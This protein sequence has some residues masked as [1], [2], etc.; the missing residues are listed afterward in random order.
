MALYFKIEGDQIVFFGDTFNNRPVLKDLGARYNGTDKTWVIKDSESARTRA[1]MF[2]KP[3]GVT[4]SAAAPK[5][6]TSTSVPKTTAPSTKSAPL[7]IDPSMGLT[8]SQ[9]MTE[10]DKI[11]TQGFP[12]PIWV[13]GEIQSLSRRGGGTMYF[14]FADAKTGAHQTATMTVKCNI[15]QNQVTWLEK[16]HGKNKID[17]I[18]AD[19]NR[20]RAL[21]NVKLYKDRGQISLSIDDVDPTFTQGALALARLELLKKLRAQGLDRKNKLLT[22]PNFPFRVALITSEGSR[23]HTDFQHQ[24]LDS[25]QF[26]GELVFI[27]CSMQGDRVPAD[28]TKALKEAAAAHVDVIVISRGGGSAADLRWFDGEEIALAIANAPV[29]VIAAIG[30]HED[31]CVAEEICHT[32][33]KTPTAAA[34]RI[35]D[36]F[37]DTKAAID[38]KAHILATALDREMIRFDRM[39]ANLR[40]R[41]VQATDY[42]FSSHRDR[43]TRMTL[44]LQRGFDGVYSDQRAKFNRMGA[45]LS[46]FATQAIQKHVE[47]L[48]QR[49]QQLTKLNPKPWLDTGWTQLSVSGKNLKSTDDVKVGTKIQ[50]RLRDGILKLTVESK[51]PR[52]KSPAGKD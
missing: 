33:E 42:Y 34:D 31:T 37:R 3:Q 41:L 10:A 8:I 23:A 45:Q 4:V 21:V 15:W 30:H 32:R 43:L 26:P 12:T 44:Q 51:E 19:G 5:A 52:T 25:G 11:I 39:Q 20:L 35:L 28:V 47:G 22:M 48:F 38:E 6:V 24:L 36:V 13:V 50:A 14:D 17:E 27:A 7:V 40:E 29:P 2:A 18:F 16:R 49:E 1:A 46:H 9:L